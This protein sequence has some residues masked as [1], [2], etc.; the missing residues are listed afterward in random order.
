MERFRFSANTGFLW[1]DRPF[2]DRLK[3]A[4]AAGF[5]GLEFHDEAQGEDPSQLRDV[6]DAC[7]LPVLGLNTRMGTT[8][9]CAAQPE[10]ADQARRDVD[11]AVAV[12]QAVRARAVH[13][14]AGK[15]EGPA[16]EAAYLAVLHHALEASDL[17]ILIEPICPQAIPGYFLN[18]LDQ[19]RRI[20]DHVGHP[21][22]KIMF[23]CYHIQTGHGDV[24]D[25]FRTC[26]DQVGH[27]QIASVPARAEPK[28]GAGAVLD[29]GMILP[30][31]RKAGYGGM[32]GCEYRPVT[33]TDAGLGWRDAV[34]RAAN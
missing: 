15:A 2:L 23:D 4:A 11:D 25:R 10:Q 29:Y 32:F 6:L 31:L 17:T 33:T 19:A 28:V 14:V 30:A 7:D 26:A 12:A 34:K 3:A 9:G 8:A 22:L 18:S 1:K 20:V 5:D 24:L 21:R 13:V 27:V 16:A